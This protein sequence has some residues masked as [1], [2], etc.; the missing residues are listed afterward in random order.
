MKDCKA[1]VISSRDFIPIGMRKRSSIGLASRSTRNVA[2]LSTTISVRRPAFFG[3]R[4]G[5]GRRRPSW[6]SGGARG[7]VISTPALVDG[8][9]T[10]AGSTSAGSAVP[11]ATRSGRWARTMLV[12]E[13]AG[14]VAPARR[15]GPCIGRRPSSTSG[16]RTA[17]TG[18]LRCNSRRTHL[19]V[20]AAVAVEQD[21]HFITPWIGQRVDQVGDHP[22]QGGRGRGSWPSGTASRFVSVPIGDRRQ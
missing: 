7:R 3:R 21:T 6:S 19:E 13:L 5:G 22:G 17:C 14:M 12:P 18:V 11:S 1:R 15:R 4:R 2:S 8:F 9:G 16:R 20:V 10:R